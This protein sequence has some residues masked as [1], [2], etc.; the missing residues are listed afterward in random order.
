MVKIVTLVKR[1]PGLTKEQF[2][3]QWCNVHGPLAVS[4]DGP[5][6]VRRYAQVD[7]LKQP[8]FG[9]K[10]LV[11]LEDAEYD[12]VAEM[13]FDDW[14]ALR[15][16]LDFFFGEAGT[17]VRDD[18]ARFCDMDSAVMYFGEDRVI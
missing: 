11:S 8:K 5:P 16:V 7:W 2:S 14:D 15:K 4:K 18:M 1:K 6:G 17:K 12:G 9:E 10:G 3:D 13:W